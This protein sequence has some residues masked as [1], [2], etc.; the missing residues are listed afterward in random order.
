MYQQEQEAVMERAPVIVEEFTVSD[1][2]MGFNIIMFMAAFLGLW[3]T[4]CII[5]AL[6]TLSSVEAA[7]KT[8]LTALLGV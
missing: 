6:S 3:G 2:R 8:L 4:A 7:G 1:S 5:S